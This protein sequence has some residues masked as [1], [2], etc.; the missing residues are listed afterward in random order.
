MDGNYARVFRGDR[1]GDAVLAL[2]FDG[3]PLPVDHGGPARLVSTDSGSG[4][5][6]SV[7]WVSQL[8]VTESEPTTD[9]AAKATALSRIE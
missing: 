4:C 1:V 7:K 5:W 6:E 8:E 2:E 9:D 3:E